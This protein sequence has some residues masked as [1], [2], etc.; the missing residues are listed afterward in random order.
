MV[1]Y[2][3]ARVSTY[4]Q[5]VRGH[6]LDAQ[7]ASCLEYAKRNGL[8]LGVETNCGTPGVFIDGGKSA[9]RKSLGGRPGGAALMQCLK[10]GCTVIC[11]AL[12]RLFRRLR[13]TVVTTE[14][15][16]SRGIHVHFLDYDLRTETADGKLKL[17]FMAAI[18]QWKSEIIRSRVAEGKELA[19][20]REARVKLPPVE[21]PPPGP[22]PDKLLQAAL[23]RV[24]EK[25]SAAV[26][27]L[28][29]YIRVS[30]SIQSVEA[31]RSAIERMLEGY[32]D[33]K[34][35]PRVWYEDAGVSAFRRTLSKRPSGSR[36]LREAVPGDMLV[37]LRPDRVFRSIRDSADVVEQLRKRGID[38]FMVEGGMRTDSPLGRAMLNMMSIVAEIESQELSKSTMLGRHQAMLKNPKA[39]ETMLPMILWEVPFKKRAEKWGSA[40]MWLS[41]E[42]RW[43]MVCQLFLFL[44]QETGRRMVRA[45]ALRWVGNLWLQKKG[46]PAFTGTSDRELTSLYLLKLNEMQKTE[47]SE[48]RRFLIGKLTQMPEKSYIY[49][50]M[51]SLLE[52]KAWAS[53]RR[54]MSQFKTLPGRVTGKALVTAL[55]GQASDPSEARRTLSAMR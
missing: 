44:Q 24:T 49:R 6:S 45:N 17:H 39:V 31:Q 15:W 16:A 14:S 1:Y 35:C 55:T 41:R 54:L 52:A 32:P 7:V 51:R 26:G 3:Y 5:F 40:D 53:V 13:D 8:L 20:L 27:T 50:P 19:R 18:A 10:P 2:I 22:L 28:R 29:I 12:H 37:A 42:D 33:L 11:V 38:L 4:E 9:Y 21:T 23:A 43:N 34:E 25:K 47:F 36:L 30:T 46:Y 48:R